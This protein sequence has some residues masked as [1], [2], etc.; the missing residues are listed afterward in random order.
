[1]TEA[2]HW[3]ELGVPGFGDLS[4]E[5]RDAIT[6]FSLPWS[7]FERRILATEGNARSICSA[8]AAEVTE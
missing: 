5:E 6:D 4:Q 2:T 8:V 7:F 1:M 3:L